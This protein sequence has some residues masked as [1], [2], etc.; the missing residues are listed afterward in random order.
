MVI[1]LSSVFWGFRENPSI[2]DGNKGLTIMVSYLMLVLICV[3]VKWEWHILIILRRKE[4]IKHHV[5]YGL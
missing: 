4:N 5:I 1:V 2:K 3:S